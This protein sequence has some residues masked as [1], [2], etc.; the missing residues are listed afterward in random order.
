MGDQFVEHSV[1]QLSA[2]LVTHGKSVGHLLLLKRLWRLR[3]NSSKSGAVFVRDVLCGA[4]AELANLS[5]AKRVPRAGRGA[6]CRILPV[7]AS[8]VGMNDSRSHDNLYLVSLF[9]K[10]GDDDLL[11]WFLH[12]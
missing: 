2:N 6:L 10:L 11:R 7:I 8:R 5:G 4:N 1:R 3:L 9:G 12:S